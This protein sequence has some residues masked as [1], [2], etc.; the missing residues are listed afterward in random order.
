MD[1]DWC[2]DRWF[3]DGERLDGLGMKT[4]PVFPKTS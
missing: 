2:G 1:S 4:E 3:V